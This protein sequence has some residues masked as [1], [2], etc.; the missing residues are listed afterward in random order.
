L[1]SFTGEFHHTIDAKGRLIVPARVREE[2]AQ[3]ELTLTVWPEGCISL[4][5]G[6][7]WTT[8]QEQLLTQRRSDPNAR[9]AVRRIFS[10]AFKDSVDK[11]GRI[12]VPQHLKD[13]AG[14]TR[15]VVI[16]GVGDHAEIW[17]PPRYSESQ[18]SADAHGLDTVFA[19]LDI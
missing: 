2:L 7:G 18:S 17:S 5:T 14:I 10:Q 9:A 1:Q 15:D 12:T 3:N 13:F 11:Q 16:A 8:L 4:W 19:A 6:E